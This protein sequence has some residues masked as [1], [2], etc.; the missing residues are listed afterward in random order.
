MNSVKKISSGFYRITPQNIL[1]ERLYLKLSTYRHNRY[2][3]QPIIVL[4]RNDW[5]CLFQEKVKDDA[6]AFRNFHVLPKK[7]T[8]L[9]TTG[10]E[11]CSDPFDLRIFCGYSSKSSSDS[12][13]SCFEIKY[14]DEKYKILWFDHFSVKAISQEDFY[15]DTSK[16]VTLKYPTN[17]ES[18]YESRIVVD[19][20]G[21]DKWYRAESYEEK[22][23]YEFTDREHAKIEKE[24]I[25]HSAHE[26][27]AAYNIDGYGQVI[28]CHSC[29]AGDGYYY[30]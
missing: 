28:K 26:I 22:L 8:I 9:L 25:I 2:G 20:K 21:S 19:L 5:H 13:F 6:Y 30:Y 14:P 17:S 23:P 24:L 1:E 11:G 16:K 27:L 18:T 15:P 3:D 29:G 12:P 10:L 7:K 4:S